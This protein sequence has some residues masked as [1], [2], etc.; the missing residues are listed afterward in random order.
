MS[1]IEIYITKNGYYVKGKTSHG[2]AH[3]WSD[4]YAFETKESLLE[5]LKDILLDPEN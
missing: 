4:S 5:G 3:N 1:E 2:M